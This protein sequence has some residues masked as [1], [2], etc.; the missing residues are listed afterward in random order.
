MKEGCSD[1]Y[2][3]IPSLALSVCL[4]L[5]SGYT[6]WFLPLA[7][8][9]AAN[10][11]GFLIPFIYLMLFSWF[12]STWQ[13]KALIFGVSVLSLGATW[14]FSAGVFLGSS[15]SNPVNISIGVTATSNAFFFLA[16]LWPL[17]SALRELDV[18]RVSLFL[19]LV[20][21][22][23]SVVWIV[24]GALVPD[25][26]IMAMNAVGLAF[27]CLQI[28]SWSYITIM[29]KGRKDDDEGGLAPSTLKVDS[30]APTP[31]QLSAGAAV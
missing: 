22:V 17:Y 23:Q 8:L 27:A 20:Q 1:K 9:Y 11:C 4:S 15:V 31:G 2:S 12:S 28:A 26:F 21:V 3:W 18:S 7:Q 10:F 19:S 5:W 16:P 14:A 29:S 24:A 13:R 6:V 30:D 25:S